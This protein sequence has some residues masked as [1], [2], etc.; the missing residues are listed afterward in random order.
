MSNRINADKTPK[1]VSY[2]D[3]ILATTDPYYIKHLGLG[4]GIAK[5]LRKK[6]RAIKEA[7][8]RGEYDH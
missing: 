3:A 5:G 6:R 8:A 4:K 1:A 2:E 7:I